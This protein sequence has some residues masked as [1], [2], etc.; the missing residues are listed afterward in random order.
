MRVTVTLDTADVALLD[1]LA[2]LEGLNR[3]AEL[4]S[5]LAQLR[6]MLRATVEAFEAAASQRQAFERAASEVE[7]SKLQQL[8]PEA[9]KLAGAYLGALARIEGLA[10]AEAAA[11]GPDDDEDPRPS[12]HGGHTPT[13]TPEDDR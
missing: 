7:V 10:A 12:N 8:L 1:R 2:A 11:Q 4:R 6:P 3:S 13:P 9:E 5:M